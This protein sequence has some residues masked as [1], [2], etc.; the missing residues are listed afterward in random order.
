MPAA[1]VKI[2]AR[3]TQADADHRAGRIDDYTRGRML[4][5]CATLET[6]LTQVLRP[7]AAVLGKHGVTVLLDI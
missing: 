1:N 7:L 5:D 4:T 2:S 3:R 6:T